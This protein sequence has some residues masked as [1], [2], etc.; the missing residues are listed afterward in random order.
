[1]TRIHPSSFT[2]QVNLSDLTATAF[3]V[4]VE[5]SGLVDIRRKNQPHRGVYAWCSQ[6]YL[7][8]KCNRSRSW[9]S[10]TICYLESLGLLEVTR[11]RWAKGTYWTN[12]YTL[13]KSVWKKFKFKLH[14]LFKGNHRVGYTRHKPKAI[15]MLEVPRASE[16][17]VLLGELI[18]RIESLATRVKGGVRNPTEGT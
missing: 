14:H 16:G 4:L 1:M 13:P 3:M 9:I 10:E 2:P 5:L 18:G 8:Q 6:A 12:L 15:S 11:R 7:A 17:P